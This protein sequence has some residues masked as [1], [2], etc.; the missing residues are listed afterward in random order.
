MKNYSKKRIA[1]DFDR[2]VHKYS[3]GWKDGSIYDDPVE[4]SIEA[5]KR[6]QK[7]GFE[8]FIFTSRSSKGAVRNQAIRRWLKKHGLDNIEVTNIKKPAIAY[9]DDRA[10]RFTHWRDMLSYFL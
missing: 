9:I 4:G 2:V 10:I 6:L 7:E 8:V 1:V 5:I 3:E